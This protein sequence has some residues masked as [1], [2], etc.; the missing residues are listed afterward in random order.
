MGNNLS[1]SC[2]QYDGPRPFASGFARNSARTE[3]GKNPHAE[4]EV[5][6]IDSSSDEDGSSDSSDS[7]EEVEIISLSKS[8]ERI[9]L[10]AR[11]VTNPDMPIF[12][13]LLPLLPSIL[14]LE[15]LP[16]QNSKQD[17]KQEPPPSKLLHLEQAPQVP[18]SLVELDQEW[19][20]TTSK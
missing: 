20:I 9:T 17:S 14:P 10:E 13:L 8:Q 3:A 18:S 2:D 11:L 12:L 15:E 19:S 16:L 5:I 4:P 7:S 6:T 1:C